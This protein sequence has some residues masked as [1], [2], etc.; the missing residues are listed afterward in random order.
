MFQFPIYQ[1]IRETVLEIT[2]TIGRNFRGLVGLKPGY[3]S[4]DI[5]YSP[6]DLEQA[7]DDW[8]D[9]RHSK[10]LPFLGA[11]F[12]P[13]ETLR[14]AFE[15]ESILMKYSEPVIPI[16]GE[17]PSY[18]EA[19]SDEVIIETLT[20]LFTALGNATKQTTVRFTYFGTDTFRC[21]YRIKFPNMSHP[22]D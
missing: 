16:Q 8:V 10:G 15:T 14:Y 22:L 11:C 20:S 6:L 7:W 3:N 4:G 19:F 17:I 21:S 13:I 9:L 18:Q 1:L 5:A 2:T 12:G